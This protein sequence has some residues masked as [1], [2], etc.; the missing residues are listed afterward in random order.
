MKNIIFFI[1]AAILTLYSLTFTGHYFLQ[2]PITIVVGYLL[3]FSVLFQF[4]K[5]IQKL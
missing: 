1:L 3:Y 4:Y 2:Y 5:L